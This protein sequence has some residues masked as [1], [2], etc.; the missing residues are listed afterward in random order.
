MMLNFG[1]YAQVHEVKQVSNNNKPRTV[2]GIALYPRSDS[3]WH[4][5][6]L[7]TGKRLHRYKWTVL[8]ATTEVENRVN[9]LGKTQNQPEVSD[10][11]IFS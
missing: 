3:S 6:S 1:D 8:P 11:V 7:E 5:M 2:G 4:F 10:N 9:E